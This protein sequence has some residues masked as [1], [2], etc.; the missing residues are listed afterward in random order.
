MCSSSLYH[1]SG[2]PPTAGTHASRQRVSE[3]GRGWLLGGLCAA[4]RVCTSAAVNM[5]RRMALHAGF[6]PQSWTC[7]L[8][9]LP[10]Q[11]KGRW[12]PVG[13][14][15]PVSVILAA[16]HAQAP[17]LRFGRSSS[18]ESDPGSPGPA[19]SLHRQ[20]KRRTR[21]QAFEAA[22]GNHSSKSALAAI[23]LCKASGAQDP[24]TTTTTRPAGGLGNGC[25]GC[26][27]LLTMQ[28]RRHLIAAACPQLPAHQQTTY[29]SWSSDPVSRP[30]SACSGAFM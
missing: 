20:N 21:Y 3:G 13:R 10:L 17:V 25:E 28:R 24:T 1:S 7:T 2:M 19:G 15:M 9:L 12:L 11:I 5:H 14:A 27:L 18:E 26:L 16:R 8:N 23:Q 6:K 30:S 22:E 4:L 29:S